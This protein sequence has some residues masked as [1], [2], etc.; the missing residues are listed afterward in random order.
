M[1]S[2][3]FTKSSKMIGLSF[4]VLNTLTILYDHVDPIFSNNFPV[5]DDVIIS[6]RVLFSAQVFLPGRG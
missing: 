2:F 3:A 5:N 1:V 6:A 4:A